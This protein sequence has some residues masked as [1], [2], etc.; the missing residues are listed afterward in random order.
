ME[1]Y[2]KD[3]ISE[4]ASL[5]KLVDDLMLVVQGAE[6]FAQAAGANLSGERKLEITSRLARLKEAC[7]NV[8]EHTRATALA[9][10]K[11][12][13]Q[14]RPI[15]QP[16]RAFSRSVVDCAC[17]FWRFCCECL[18]RRADFAVCFPD[19]V[20]FPTRETPKS[21][22]QNYEACRCGRPPASHH[23]VSLSTRLLTD[24]H[25]HQWNT[26]HNLTPARLCL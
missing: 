11:V 4:D 1:L 3:L 8:K 5:E 24:N 13:R 7:R 9:A 15:V 12:L 19:A 18:I 16:A 14:K 25:R 2:Y 10:D 21:H 23:A 20:T 6:E 17:L 26:K 22:L